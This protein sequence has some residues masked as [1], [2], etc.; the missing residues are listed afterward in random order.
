[1]C[2]LGVLEANATEV[3]AIMGGTDA[4]C[5]HT[6]QD[7]LLDHNPALIAD[8]G[9]GMGDRSKVDGAAP[10][11]TKNPGLDGGKVIE[12]LVA[13][14]RGNVGLTIFEVDEAQAWGKAGECRHEVGIVL[15]RAKQIMTAIK[16]DAD[17]GGVGVGEEGGDFAG[18]FDDARTMMVEGTGEP[19][20]LIDGVGDLAG[21]GTGVG[22]DRLATWRLYAASVGG[23]IGVTA[24]V[25]SQN[26]QGVMC[27]PENL[28]R[29]GQELGGALGL[30]GGGG[31]LG[32]IPL[33]RHGDKGANQ[34]Q[35]ALLECGS[36]LAGVGRHKAPI[37]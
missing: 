20:T 31:N 37:A 22:Q 13:G 35:L 34:G 26:N 25:V 36:E 1:M 21:N 4:R 33:Q 18:S 8:G 16:Y 15:T 9:E 12:L 17:E 6:R 2:S 28:G 30:I 23:A 5:P 3:G 32:S 29:A 10:Q 27:L 14:A 24:V 19:A 11:L 7:V